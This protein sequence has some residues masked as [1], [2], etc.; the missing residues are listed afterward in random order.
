M[1]QATDH[2]ED[3]ILTGLVNGTAIQTSSGKPYIGLF[4]SAPSDTG[5]GTECSGGGYARIQVGSTVNGFTQSNFTV[6]GGTA[7]ND[8]EFK[9]ADATANWGTVSHI[10]VFDAETGGDLLVY[11]AL[12]SPVAIETGDIFKVPANGYTITVD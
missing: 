10:G 11:G 8:S 2:T 12:T 7:Q 3:L 5:G 1:S 4:T 9:F 6:N